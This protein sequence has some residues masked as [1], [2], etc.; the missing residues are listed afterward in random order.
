MELW[1]N[2]LFAWF[3]LVLSFLLIVIWLLR[4]IYKNK[5]IP[6]IHKVNRVLRRRHKIIGLLLIG[7]ALVHGLFSSDRVFSLNWG[8]ANWAVSILL[9]LSWLL[10]KKLNLKKW[11]LYIH[12]GLTAGF[13]GLL[14]VHIINA[15][16]FILDDMI[17]ERISQPQ[18][19]EETAGRVP[20]E[21]RS[22]VTKEVAGSGLTE[23]LKASG[24]LDGVYQGTASG[25]RP[26]LVVEVVIENG[27]IVSAAVID[28]NE[29]NERF[30]GYPVEVVPQRIVEAQSTDVDAVSGATYTSHGIKNAVDDAL[31]KAV[32]N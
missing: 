8:T 28:H 25:F 22:P 10:R 11:W 13:I 26:G 27:A 4:V 21:T 12:R 15:G 29:V 30:W 14:F 18:A 32:P 17:T 23:T 20:A 3:A 9:G 31:S 19:M 16:G 24:Y 7:T 5:K 2:I 1:I 6:W